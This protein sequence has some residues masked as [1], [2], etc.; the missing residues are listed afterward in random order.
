MA[1]ATG[2]IVAAAGAAS[3]SEAFGR[4][5]ADEIETVMARAAEGVLATGEDDPALVRQAM[6]DAKDDF[7]AKRA[8]D[9]DY[10][11]GDD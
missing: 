9:P 6:L 7:K 2:T 4:W 8:A 3:A 5:T 1:K 11:I 10:E